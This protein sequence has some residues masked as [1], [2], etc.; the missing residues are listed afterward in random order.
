MGRDPA[1]RLQWA[2][3]FARR[4]I[5]KQTGGDW[6]NLCAE[7]DAFAT[8][9]VWWD[10]LPKY[11]RKK[12]RQDFGR[13]KFP[14]TITFSPPSREVIRQT[15]ARFRAVLADLQ[16]KRRAD[17]GPI[18]VNYAILWH[19]SPP[20]RRDPATELHNMFFPPFYVD[21]A[22][23][24]RPRPVQLVG[25]DFEEYALVKFAELLAGHPGLIRICPEQKKCGH[26]FVARRLNQEYCSK[27]C[28]TRA[29]VRAFRERKQAAQTK[30]RHRSK[31]KS[32]SRRRKEARR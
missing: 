17:I 3:E 12:L 31:A 4:D 28:Q 32:R 25:A 22:P 1:D 26:W 24:T 27:R 14:A 21:I 19:R 11:H 23:Q 20:R 9:L 8:T 6:E 10:R 7:I 29:A 30:R 18:L 16:E 2:L 15:Q 5:D 13:H